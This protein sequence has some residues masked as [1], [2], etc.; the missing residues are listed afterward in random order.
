[1][2]GVVASL[3][4]LAGLLREA[5]G[6]VLPADVDRWMACAVAERGRWLATGVPMDQRRP[7]LLN[8]LVALYGHDQ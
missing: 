8:A 7:Q 1:M 2:S 3:Q 5:L 6:A 4:A